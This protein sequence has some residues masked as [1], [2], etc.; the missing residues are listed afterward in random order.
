MKHLEIKTIKYKLLEQSFKEWLQTLGYA[1]STVSNLPSNLREFFHYSENKGITDTKNITPLHISNFIEYFKNRK[2]Q[3]RSGGLSIA[4]INRQI[5][6]L[7]KFAR[8]MKQTG[9]AEITVKTAYLKEDNPPERI[10]LSIEEIKQLYKVCDTSPIGT[11]DKAMLSVYY[12]CGLRKSEGLELEISDILFD[13]KLLYIRKTK[14]NYERYVPMSKTVIKDLENY[15]YESRP[16]LLSE[17]NTEQS[18]FISE[19]GRKI[20]PGSMVSRLQVLKQNTG[21]PELQQKSFG[22]HALRHSIATHLL[23]KGMDIEQIALFLGH[24]TL[25]STQIYTHIVNEL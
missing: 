20:N 19:R 17:E 1:K 5:D 23:Q 4:H 8:Y 3:R 10:I 9:Q 7:H 16:F 18:L 2:N 15:I 13:R 24:R 14:N 22:L 21:N 25:D 11:R 12:G 6:T